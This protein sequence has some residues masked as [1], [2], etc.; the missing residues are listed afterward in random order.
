[1]EIANQQQVDVLK[2]LIFR[3]AATTSFLQELLDFLPACEAKLIGFMVD[4]GVWQ[5][6]VP[7]LSLDPDPNESTVDL[8]LCLYWL[9]NPAQLDL[10]QFTFKEQLAIIALIIFLDEFLASS[11]MTDENA[12]FFKTNELIYPDGSVLST[13]KYAT[14]DQGWFFAFLNLVESVMHNLWYNGGVFPAIKPPTIP[15]TGAAANSVSIAI[16]GDW[17]TGDAT[18]QAVMAAVTS[19]KPDYIVHVGDVYYAGTPQATSPNG[20]YYFATGEE[21][22]NLIAV[23]P[24][25]YAGRSFT[26]NSNHEM[27]S[28]ANGYFYD[29]LN[30]VNGGAGSF[31]SA[32]KGSSCFALKYGGW[33]I[34]GLDTAFMSSSVDA[35][36]TGSIGGRNGTQGQWIQSLGLNPATTI[37]LTHHNGFAPDCSSAS[38]LWAEIHGALRGD[39]YAWYWGHVHN[40]IVYNSPVTIPSIPTQPGFTTNTFTRCLGHAALPYGPAVLND[41]T[42]AWCAGSSQPPPSK[43]LFNG[44][45]LLTLTVNSSNQL[46]GITESFYDLS[47]NKAVWTK[48]IF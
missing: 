42:V 39:P 8:G 38:P 2:Q 44:F 26:L 22:A 3:D 35:F 43:Q 13:K 31:F 6:P 1:M 19:L 7:L 17:G 23:W 41:K 40:G 18:A 10:S 45:A 32:Q 34:L 15:L 29:G 33:T 25:S 30:V 21:I 20:S 14:Y 24:A 46:T 37:V 11:I 47:M 9:K 16:L 4:Q 28:G 5:G 27:Y 12:A 48:K 36:M